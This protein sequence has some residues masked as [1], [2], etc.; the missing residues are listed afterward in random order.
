MA[1]SGTETLAGI[2]TYLFGTAALPLEV[3]LLIAVCPALVRGTDEIR[4]SFRRRR[5]HSVPRAGAPWAAASD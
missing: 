5:H 4:R 2:V 1:D 3:V